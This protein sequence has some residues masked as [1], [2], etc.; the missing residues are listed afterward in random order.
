MSAPILAVTDLVKRF[1]G[2]AATDGLSL[3]VLPGETHALIGP[4]GAGKTTLI[5]QLQG[6]LTPDQGA[7][8]FRGEDV[9]RLPPH[10]RARRG[11]ARSFQITS[12]FPDF[13]VLQN[14]ALAVQGQEA[15]GFRFLRQ[16]GRDRRLVQPAREALDVIG[17]SHRAE[18]EARDLSHGERRQLEL[19]M[20]LAMRPSLLLLDEPMAGIGRQEGIRM[21]RI[22]EGLKRRYSI[23]LVE[24][25]MDA[26]FAL[27]D[28][29]SVLVAGRA[30]ATGDPQAIR[31]DP[32]VREAYLG[33]RH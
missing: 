8:L 4:N 23:L 33:K 14:V 17:L 22:L 15:H 10:A 7:I 21:T 24:H 25:D 31:A 32:A 5:A 1:G 16:A 28:R 30:I 6:E 3:D 2:L 12:V 29:V 26:V 9:T 13:T 11:I 19:A 27:A 20:A 18:R